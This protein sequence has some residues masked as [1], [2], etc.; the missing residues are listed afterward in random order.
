MA[1]RGAAPTVVVDLDGVVWLSGHGLPGA[2]DAIATLRTEGFDVL[3]ATNN[4]S[5]TTAQFVERLANVDIVTDEGSVVTSAH[6]AALE[7]SSYDSV[8]VLGEVGVQEAIDDRGLVRSDQPSAVVVGWSRTFTF[9]VV[10]D[11]ARMIRQGGAFIATNDDATHPTPDG[12]LPGTGSLVA[13]I[14]TAAESTPTI[15]GKPGSAMARLVQERSS[16]VVAMIGDRP[17]TDGRFAT[18]LNVPFG[19]VVSDATPDSP[20]EA[21]W[22]ASS[23]LGVV[24]QLIETNPVA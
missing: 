4:S 14:A 1:T 23:L 6:A 21:T 13:A 3:F 2:S 20:V 18:V 24:E 15:A 8:H 9:D 17:S 7:A 22:R 19:L 5:P 12:L 16:N 10:T 11:I